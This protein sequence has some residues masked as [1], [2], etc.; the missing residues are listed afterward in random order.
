MDYANSLEDN[1]AN[2]FWQQPNNKADKDTP[3]PHNTQINY[4]LNP[5]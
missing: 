1:K 5:R 4:T 3:I 2:T